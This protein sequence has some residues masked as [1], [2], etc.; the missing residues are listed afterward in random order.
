MSKQFQMKRMFLLWSMVLAFFTSSFATPFYTA[1]IDLEL[2]LEVDDPNLSI[3]TNSI[4]TLKV[5]N[6]GDITATNVTIDFPM[7]DGL[8]Y[9]GQEED[10]GEYENWSGIWKVGA[11]A[12]GQTA[13]LEL[14]LFSLT[15]GNPI[16][17][18]AQVT[19][20][21]EQDCDSTPN[22]GVCC[23]AV[24]D[25]EAAVTI[26]GTIDNMPSLSLNCTDDFTV[27]VPMG[28][29]SA[30]VT[31]PE[32]Q[33]ISNNCPTYTI[34]YSI[35]G[36]GTS[37]N[38]IFDLG[39]GTTAIRIAAIGLNGCTDECIFNITVKQADSNSN[40]VDM[41][42][43]LEASTSNYE[44]YQNITYSLSA[45]NTGTA[46]ATGIQINLP[47]PDGF[48]FSDQ[49]VSQGTY[50]D[51]DGTWIVGDL[52]AGQSATLDLVLF[53]LIE[54]S[55]VTAYAQLTA[56]DQTDTDSSPNNGTCCT[57]NEDDEAAITI[58]SDANLPSLNMS[59]SPSYT[60]SVDPNASSFQATIPEPI[61]NA[62]NCPSYTV[63]YSVDG[64]TASTNNIVDLTVG[65]HSINI[66]VLGI[67]GC[68]ADCAFQI[69]IDNTGTPPTTGV[70][71]TAND[72][73]TPYDGIFRPGINMG[74]NPPW[75]D[76]ELANIA[77]GNPAL[78]ID[79]LGTKTIRPGLY[80]YITTIFGYDIRVDAFD[81]YEELGMDDLTMIVGFPVDWH[82]D[83][84]DYCGDGNNSAMFANLY[85]DIWDNGE[86]GTP[87]ND[88]NY[89]AA[90]L[91]EVVSRYNDHVRFWEIWN[92]PGFDLTGQLG[93]RPP[94]DPV[95]NWWD[96]DPDPCENILRAP[97]EHYVRTLRISWEI[98]KSIAP[99]DYVVVAGVGFES[100]LDA[101][102]RNTD[103]PDGGTV[104]AEYPNYGGA[105]FDVMGYHT[106]PDIDGSVRESLGNN[107]FNF[108]R[109]SDAAANGVLRRKTLWQEVLSSHGYDGNTY[110]N[111]EWIITEINVPRKGFRDIAMTGG[112]DLQINYIIKAVV[113][114]MR[115]DVRQMHVY[116]LGD[117][118]PEWQATE[119]FDLLGLY[120]HLRHASEGGDEPYQQ[121]IH[122]QGHAYKT[123]SDLLYGTT[124]DANR[125]SMMALPNE[126]DGGAFAKKNGEYVYVIWAKTTIDQSEFASGSY[127]FPSG[128]GIG[129]LY[130]KEWNYSQTGQ[131][132][133]INPQNIALTARPIFLTETAG[134]NISNRVVLTDAPH[135]S[136]RNIYPNPTVEELKLAVQ[137]KESTLSTIEIYNVQ[138][139]LQMT[140]QVN[141]KRGLNEVNFMVKDFAPGIYT[142][143][144][145]GT[146][147]ANTKVQ[148]VKQQL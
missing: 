27:E 83:L 122:Q 104:T 21:S 131:T 73:V 107:N 126:L 105:Y 11:L 2:S 22:N 65:T 36:G 97:I 66:A 54:G 67:M 137:C 68:T 30:M 49:M 144:I 84:T 9:V 28:Q 96:R 91:Y 94:G 17:S 4:Y 7:P 14:T 43:A 87:Y 138:G 56:L 129:Q 112:E 10:T 25:D 119:E 100:F 77:A 39:L 123:T 76:E 120:D 19:N 147:N 81:H 110:P 57:P 13:T 16:T 79:G 6:K 146:H 103:N 135:L 102:L 41:E 143:Q 89:Y 52:D 75:T 117:K 116:T 111:K 70:G 114:A 24:E 118:K 20:A 92:E 78:G 45:S 124:Y 95:G 61:I 69:T 44:I 18:Y 1:A 127:S 130:K 59:C 99:E 125:T 145:Q 60:I 113:T 50:S 72:Q 139:T 31:I 85:T 121:K 109:H 15:E 74:Y 115:N 86:N 88:N 8:V 82:R 46:K 53:S 128:M 26:G 29:T 48:V 136:I 34:T 133:A 134:G 5:L 35:N 90:Y 148:F 40:T 47:K 62:S 23:T 64:G 37:T 106:Y 101:I 58:T 132:N 140:K 38:N 55:A 93:W 12:A 51:W 108:F 3:F 80:D 33:I 98:I 63:T 141:L 142:V 71:Y 32:P 42:L